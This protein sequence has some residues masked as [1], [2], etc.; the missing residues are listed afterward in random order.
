MRIT[1]RQLRGIIREALTRHLN[2]SFLDDCIDQ[3]GEFDECDEDLL[4][5]AASQIN[6]EDYM[7]NP[8]AGWTKVD[9]YI[10]KIEPE[11]P[12]LQ[13]EFEKVLKQQYG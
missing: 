4:L 7:K 5:H 12:S 1:K 11:S 2:E 9:K 8:K 10:S 6:Y 13:D 3:G